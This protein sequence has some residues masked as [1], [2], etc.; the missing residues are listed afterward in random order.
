MQLLNYESIYMVI[1]MDLHAFGFIVEVYLQLCVYVFYILFN[2]HFL[3][4][5]Y[6]VGFRPSPFSLNCSNISQYNTILY[7]PEEQFMIYPITY[8]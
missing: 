2:D 5:G 7:Y 4:I 1:S 3:L 8:Y 6:V